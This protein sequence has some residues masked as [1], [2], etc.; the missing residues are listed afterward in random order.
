MGKVGFLFMHFRD[1]SLSCNA[2][3]YLKRQRTTIKTLI[4]VYLI[5]FNNEYSTKDKDMKN[6]IGIIDM[7]V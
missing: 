6:E 5:Y 3:T 1:Y 4:L 2:L 7:Y